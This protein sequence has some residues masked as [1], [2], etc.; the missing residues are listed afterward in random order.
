MRDVLSEKKK[1]MKVNEARYINMPKYDE[2]SVRNIFPKFIDD[3]LVMM[4]LQDEYPKDRFP[5]RQ[6]FFTVLNTVHPDYVRNI[7]DHANSQRFSAQGQ[8][9]ETQRVAVSDEWW[10]ELNRLPYFSRKYLSKSN[11]CRF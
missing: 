3:P 10:E 1:L 11:S 8:A 9:S 6:Y 2:L 7:I 4:Y 5:D